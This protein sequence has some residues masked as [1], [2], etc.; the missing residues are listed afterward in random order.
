M[1]LCLSL[2]SLL[3]LWFCS[4]LL[5]F[6]NSYC[7][8]LFFLLSAFNLEFLAVVISYQLVGFGYFSYMSKCVPVFIVFV[9]NFMF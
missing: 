6:T 3:E 9:W 1:F 7:F 4:V 8:I 2:T 5:V